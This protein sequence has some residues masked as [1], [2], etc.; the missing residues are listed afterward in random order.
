[1]T[2]KTSWLAGA[3]SRSETTM[4]STDEP[5]NV[6]E[7]MDPPRIMAELRVLQNNLVRIETE[8]LR[9]LDRKEQLQRALIDAMKDY[10][11]R[12]EIVP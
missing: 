5:S 12:G 4:E 11:I 7:I 1:M 8:G 9:L 3:L 2:K 10:G 6:V